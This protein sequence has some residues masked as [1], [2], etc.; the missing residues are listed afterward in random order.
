M[1]LPDVWVGVTDHHQEGNWTWI[2]DRVGTSSDL[3]WAINQPDNYDNREHCGELW[4]D[5]N[6]YKL[7]DEPCS[8]TN[9][10]L[11]EKAFN[12]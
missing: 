12:Y 3:M 1:D 2:D 9:I 5:Y 7:N 6:S 4:P 11:C 10:G 8:N